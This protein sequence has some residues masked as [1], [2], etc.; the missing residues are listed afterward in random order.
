M[1]HCVLWRHSGTLAQ[2]RSS[3]RGD[4]HG[5]H[6]R[7]KT[8]AAITVAT[9]LFTVSTAM[10]V[11]TSGRIGS[12]RIDVSTRAA[13]VAAL[14]SPAA[15]TVGT[16][17]GSRRYRALGYT[18]STTRATAAWPLRSGGPYCQTIFF[19]SPGDGRLRDFYTHSSRYR[20]ASDVRIGMTTEIAERLL[21]RLV[22]VGCESNVYLG[23][24]TVAFSGGHRA[25][26]G[27]LVGGR[28]SAFVLHSVHGH[29]LGIFDCL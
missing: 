15:E 5:H 14:G 21:H 8:A 20:L 29:D 19:L 13:I 10:I 22:I 23:S 25:S 7:V 16:F 24:L 28:V 27:H 18:C 6:E 9:T 3:Y 26:D 1:R 12:L 2:P 4:G 17:S 11:T